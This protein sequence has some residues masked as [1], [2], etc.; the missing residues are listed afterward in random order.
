MCS[1]DLLLERCDGDLKTAIVVSFTEAAPALAVSTLESHD[2]SVKAA[3]AELVA[4]GAPTDTGQ[5]SGPDSSGPDT[6]GPDT[7][8]P[9]T[10]GA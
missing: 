2:G 9:G 8:G 7:P 5:A 6:P 10:V 3:I 4:A 1:S